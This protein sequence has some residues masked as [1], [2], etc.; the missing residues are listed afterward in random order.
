MNLQTVSTSV[1]PQHHVR[2]RHIDWEAAV[3]ALA[4]IAVVSSISLWNPLPKAEQMAPVEAS[5]TLAQAPSR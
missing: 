1:K 5:N 4:L 2:R 3:F